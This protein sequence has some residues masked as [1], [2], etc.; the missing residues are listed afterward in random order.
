MR[1][2]KV[3]EIEI[4]RVNEKYSAWHITY[5]NEE[6]LRRGKFKDENLKVLM[7]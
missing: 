7:N 3:L 2:E 4:I 6:V 1:K 5:Q